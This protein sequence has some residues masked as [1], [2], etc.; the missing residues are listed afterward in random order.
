[1]WHLEENVI[2]FAFHSAKREKMQKQVNLEKLW[3]I[4]SH[5]R[6]M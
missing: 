1:M 3:Y 4:M 2:G 6:L 5:L